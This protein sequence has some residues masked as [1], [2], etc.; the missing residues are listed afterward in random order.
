MTKGG[1]KVDKEG[2]GAKVMQTLSWQQIVVLYL[3]PNYFFLM[4]RI[5]IKRTMARFNQYDF[6]SDLTLIS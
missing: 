2:G 1:Q 6:F 4:K 5:L 3:A